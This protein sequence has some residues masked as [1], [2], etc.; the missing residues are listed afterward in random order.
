[1]KVISNSAI[2]FEFEGYFYDRHYTS[3]LPRLWYPELEEPMSF[4]PKQVHF[5]MG[6]GTSEHP[7]KGSEHNI[8]GKPHDLEMHIVNVNNDEET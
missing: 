5:H 3:S 7:G 6:T 2:E 4:T 8:D 1:M